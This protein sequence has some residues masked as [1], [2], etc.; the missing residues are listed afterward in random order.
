MTPRESARERLIGYACGIGIVVIWTGF[1][2]VSRAGVKGELGP[3][4]LAALRFAVS[5]LVML[6]VFLMRSRMEIPLTR[7]A[8]LAFTAGLA[9]ATLAYAGFAYAPAAHGGVL[10]PGALPIFTAT[11]AVFVLGERLNG[12]RIASLAIVIA[13]IGMIGSHG[14][15][16]SAPG[17][18]RGDLL[19]LCA[20]LCWA[21]YTVLVRRWRLAAIPAT[22]S[23]A[24][25][26]AAVFL[27]L[28]ALVLPSRL[29]SAPWGEIAFQ[30]IYQG[31]FAVVI[32]G[33]LYTRAVGA[34][35]AGRT[36]MITAVIPATSA[37]AAVPLLGEP[38]SALALAGVAAV[39]VG[40][41]VGVR[42]SQ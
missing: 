23:V 39:S 37:L 19:F 13:G 26:S 40:M 31:L 41:I 32:A 6:P 14:L 42:A 29:A 30:A 1:I 2:L 38:L 11:L 10:L 28:Y 8:A 27:P 35:G 15:I 20:S 9:Y 34:L 16:G 17:A 3:L 5:G 21:T 24:V 7:A 12:A 4:D 36:T 33:I 22:A 25:L 18:W